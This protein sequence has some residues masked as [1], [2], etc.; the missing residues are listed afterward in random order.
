[1]ELKRYSNPELTKIA[2]EIFYEYLSKDEEGI[3]NVSKV[4]K[5]YEDKIKL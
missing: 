2:T 4:L 5:R 3:P 1:M